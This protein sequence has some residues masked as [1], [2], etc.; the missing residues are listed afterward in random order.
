ME[1]DMETSAKS[2]K[3]NMR[4]STDALLLLREAASL[5]QQDLTSFVLGA[6]VAQARQTMLEHRTMFLSEAEWQGLQAILEDETPVAPE[7][8]ARYAKYKRATNSKAV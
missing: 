2:Q 3:I 7:I 5:N 4:I 8:V 1:E 6:A